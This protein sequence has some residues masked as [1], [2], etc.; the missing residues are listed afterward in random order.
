MYSTKNISKILND[1]KS[2]DN[3]LRVN[4]CNRQI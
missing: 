3:Y 1:A 4:L 2:K